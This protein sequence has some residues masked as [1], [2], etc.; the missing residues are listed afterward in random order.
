MQN[1][2]SRKRRQLLPQE[3]WQVFLEVTT[4]QLSQSDARGSGVW[5]SVW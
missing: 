2:M 4:G 5:M 1:G 3:K